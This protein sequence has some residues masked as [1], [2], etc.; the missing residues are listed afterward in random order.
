MLNYKN[1]DLSNIKTP[2][3]VQEFEKL[4]RI[5][6]YNEDE[7]DFLI[8]GFSYGF[9]L[10]YKGPKCI[11]Q[12]SNNLKFT[13]GDKYELWNK[14]MKEVKEGRYAG[15]YESP[16]FENY[17]QSPIGLVPKDGGKK[18]RLIF[19]LSHPRDSSKGTSV[20]ANIPDRLCKVKYKKLDDAIR[21]CIKEGKGCYLGKSDMS[22]AFRH[23]A[24]K[25]KC[26]KYLLMKAQHPTNNKWY[27]FVDKCMPFGASISCS[28]FQ[29]FSD[30]IAHI[31]K[32]LVGKDNI[33][34]LDD[35]LFA[36]IKKMLCNNQL[37]TFLEVC[38][39]INFPVSMEKTFWA[40]TRMIFLGLL[41]DTISQMI[42]IPVEKIEKARNLI[43]KVLN[44]KSK[45]ITLE[46]LQKLTGF[47]N[48]LGRAVVPG[49]AF[50]R[51]LYCIEESA[52][53]KSLKKH[54][55]IPIKKEMRMD[56]E[57]WLEFLNHPNI[58]AR[59][60][61]DMDLTITSEEVDFY[62]DA[63]ANKNL[64]CGGICGEDWFI[65]QWNEDFIKEKNPSINYLELYAVTIGIMSWIQKFS[66]KRIF[67]F[68]DNMSVV[69][70]INNT[71]SKCKNC[72]VLIRL[73]VLQALTHNV[74]INAKHVAGV[75]NTFADQLSRLK[76]REFWR[77]ARRENRKFNCTPSPIPD[78]LG[79]NRGYMDVIINYCSKKKKERSSI[80]N[81]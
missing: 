17:I 38:R 67:I 21:L 7:I 58:Y 56:L 30:A 13:I 77:T 1:F 46:D 78:I 31:V 6:S 52:I 66:N 36:A 15:P 16:P 9:D 42:C 18:T 33:N 27:Y 73:I 35:F 76:Y 28:H 74:K 65:M 14:V 61:I 22:S 37:N 26:W 8:D 53:R 3:N 80:I 10:C 71:T 48:F 5:T 4:L 50:T 55:H 68:C 45:K 49:R 25:K 62:T 79:I 69:H 19:H 20:N 63:S 57:M 54:H 70:M 34:Y 11:Q 40:S 59:K 23:F 51:R 39:K 29:R 24:M 43:T 60:F 64:G 2:V 12:N 41:L 75:S 47:L 72:M 44:K 81:N 32:T